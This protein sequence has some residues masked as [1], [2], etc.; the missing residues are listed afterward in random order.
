MPAPLDTETLPDN[1]IA[2][3]RLS[4]ELQA[5][6]NG[7]QEQVLRNEQL[8]QRLAPAPDLPIRRRLAITIDR[9]AQAKYCDHLPLYRRA[10][11]YTRN[12]VD[13]DRSILAA[14][15]GQTAALMRPLIA[16]IG[17][18]VMAAG[19]VMRPVALGRKNWLFAGSDA[20][21]ERAAAIYTLTETAKLN[22]LDPE[23]Y[24]RQVLGRIAEHPVK[25]VRKLL[26]WNL[27]T[28]RVRLDQ[29]NAA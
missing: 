26:P 28:A 25:R 19:R 11:I 17:A 8:K 20:G 3:R 27:T 22:G 13:L 6:R 2:L 12:G 29:R 5:A 4:A 7:L 23:D 16:A 15:V 10:E 1:V 9:N 14:W 21:G 18:H 24:L